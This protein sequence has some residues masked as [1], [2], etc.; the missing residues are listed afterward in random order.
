MFMINPN[1]LLVGII[2]LSIDLI[3]PKRPDYMLASFL[4]RLL[5]MR[6]VTTEYMNNVH[7]SLKI[8]TQHK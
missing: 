7:A 2:F 8:C 6:N 1:Y 5:E 3:V 4:T